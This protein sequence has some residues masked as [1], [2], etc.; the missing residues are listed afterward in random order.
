[1]A[2]S[3]ACVGIGM[4]LGAHICPLA[5]SYIEQADVVFSGV[6]NGIVELWLQEMHGDVRSLQV[7]Y[8][9]GKSRHVT[10]REMVD[11]ILAE[12]RQGKKVVGAFYGHPGVFAQ[13]PHRSIEAAR[14]EGFEAVMVPGISAEDCLIADLGIDPGQF[15]CQ[16]FE[17]SQFMFYQRRFDPSCYLILWQIGLAGD[18]SMARFAT[19]KAHRQVLIELLAETYPLD[20]QVILYEA[21]VLPI[22][23]VRKQS[24]A[25]R[26]LA[27]AEIFMHTTLVIPPSEKMRPNP[28]I[29]EKLA[30]LE[31]AHRVDDTLIPEN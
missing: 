29:L 15:G 31:T 30:K 5:R 24:L 16:Q 4:T 14:A 27:D 12:V 19:G 23:K 18:K 28:T 22:D 20:H 1:M 11:A 7:Y 10:Y 9:E 26:E 25:L 6:S 8:D 21:A 17:A 13:A 2:G 3:L